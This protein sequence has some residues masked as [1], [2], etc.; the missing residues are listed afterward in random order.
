MGTV[1]I[2]R[3]Y[4]AGGRRV[5]PAL[6]E[7]LGYRFVDREIVEQA[8]RRLGLDPAA[9]AERDER[10]PG[11]VEEVGLALARGM[12]EAPAMPAAIGDRELAGAVRSVIESLAE[13]GGYVILGRGGQVALRGRPDVCHLMLVGDPEDRARRVAEWQRIDE[14]EAR[15]RCDR[16]DADRAEY[17]R[18][19]LGAD[20]RDPL[21]Y[22]AILNTSAMGIER[23]RDLAEAV[24]RPR[25][26]T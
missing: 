22:D 25:V 13:T 7:R 18:R 12:P 8:A 2:S 24:A 4:G 14:R 20:I 1:T 3:L 11:L 9:A 16:V 10:V 6:A 17:V 19:F 5:G 15:R 26:E 23:A 21:L